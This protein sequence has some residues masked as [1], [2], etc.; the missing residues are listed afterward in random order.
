MDN[1][2]R[3]S[4]LSRSQVHVPVRTAIVSGDD[5]RNG[6]SW[7]IPTA[8]TSINRS[9]TTP[10]GTLWRVW[11]PINKCL[12]WQHL[13]ALERC[14]HDGSGRGGPRRHPTRPR[15]LRGAQ[16]ERGGGS[17]RPLPLLGGLD[18]PVHFPIKAASRCAHPHARCERAFLRMSVGYCNPPGLLQ[19]QPPMGPGVGPARATSSVYLVYRKKGS[20]ELVL[21]H[22]LPVQN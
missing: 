5:A 20:H 15:P 22:K 14:D 12:R 10:A 18:S 3:C 1:R 17:K 4:L 2:P 9:L 13:A 21:S 6:S 11:L 8:H 16:I 19:H 7:V